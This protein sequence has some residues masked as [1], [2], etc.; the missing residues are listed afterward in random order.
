[1][2]ISRFDAKAMAAAVDDLSKED[3][4]K[5]IDWL[6]AAPGD[7]QPLR[8]AIAK[9]Y[10]RQKLF[11]KEKDPTCVFCDFGEEHEH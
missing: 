11:P 5:V 2:S 3:A 4:F 6:D 7:N 10:P 9:K 8:E 1:M